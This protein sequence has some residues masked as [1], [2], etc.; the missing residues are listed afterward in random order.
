MQDSSTHTTG[1]YAAL[2]KRIAQVCTAVGDFV[3]YWGFKAIHGR[4]WTFLALHRDPI[5]QADLA[6]SLGVSRAGVSSAMAELVRFG[7]VRPMGPGRN[8]PYEAVMEVWPTIANVLRTREWMLVETAR[9][10]LEA[11][12]EEARLAK[13]AGLQH[14][15]SIERLRVLL[16][17]TELAQSLLKTLIALRTPRAAEGLRAWGARA[18]LFM[19]RPTQKPSTD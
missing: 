3:E 7:L 1:A 16:T 15:Y 8:A 4:I 10:D 19:R 12:L 17:M 14:P 11:A 9:L 6:R 2:A 5:T 13:R 18:V